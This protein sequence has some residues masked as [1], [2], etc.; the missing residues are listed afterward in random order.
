M[1]V[2]LK[3]F[4]IWELFVIA[5]ENNEVTNYKVLLSSESEK[6]V[7]VDENL[8]DG[9]EP[10]KI[11]SEDCFVLEMDTFLILEYIKQAISVIVDLK[12]EDFHQESTT[13]MH[14]SSVNRKDP[15]H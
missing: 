14:K 8:L 10:L 13:S 3:V 7:L 1:Y 12:L 4:W 2:T 15:N 5:P 9:E 11:E 6:N